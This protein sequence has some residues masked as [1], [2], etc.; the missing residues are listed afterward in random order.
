[1]TITGIYGTIFDIGI[2][3]ISSAPH[4]LSRGISL[5]TMFFCTTVWIL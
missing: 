4:A 3:K 1:M 5:L 2:S